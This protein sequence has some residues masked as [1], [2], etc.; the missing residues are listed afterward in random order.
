MREVADAIQF[1]Q[2]S[3]DRLQSARE[4][5]QFAEQ[6]LAAQEQKLIGGKGDVSFV[7]QAQTDVASARTREILAKRDYN[8]ALAQLDFAEGTILDQEKI[9]IVIE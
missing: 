6:A 7:L 2:S 1:A 5:T 3:Y 4:A 8:V 9:D